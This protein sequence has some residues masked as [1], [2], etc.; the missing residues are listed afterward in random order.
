MERSKFL[1]SK[2]G[3]VEVKIVLSNTDVVEAYKKERANTEWKFEK[4]MI[5]T[6]FVALL[7]EISMGCKDAVLPEAVTKKYSINCLTY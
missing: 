1:A 5:F 3:L 6:L 4:H 7:R 2:K